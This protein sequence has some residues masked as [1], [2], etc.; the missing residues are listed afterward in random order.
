MDVLTLYD[1]CI[2]YNAFLNLVL[3]PGRRLNGL[4]CLAAVLD[5][6]QSFSIAEVLKVL[7][8]DDQTETQPFETREYWMLF[9]V[10]IVMLNVT[11]WF[12]SKGL[13]VKL[14]KSRELVLHLTF[15]PSFPVSLNKSAF[16]NFMLFKDKR[17]NLEY[18]VFLVCFGVVFLFLFFTVW[19]Q[20]SVQCGIRKMHDMFS[21]VT[22]KYQGLSGLPFN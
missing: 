19:Q 11:H 18:W 20:E 4:K 5:R 3:V 7:G 9:M 8:A 13:I 22:W 6:M 1:Y 10:N 17:T 15:Q 12:C 21:L 14:L 2:I 16:N